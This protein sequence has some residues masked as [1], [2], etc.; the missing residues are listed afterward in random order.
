MLHRDIWKFHNG[1]IPEGHHIHHED[2]DFNNNEISNLVCLSSAAH[3]V[4]HREERSARAKSPKHLAHLAAIRPLANEWHKT[5]ECRAWAREQAKRSILQDWP[6]KPCIIC[7]T[8][9]KPKVTKA[10]MCSEE[11]KRQQRNT[12]MRKRYSSKPKNDIAKRKQITERYC[13]ICGSV[14]I[15]ASGR[16]LVCGSECRREKTR[17][18]ARE[19]YHSRLRSDGG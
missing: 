14:F 9:F 11:C 2:G 12:L 1:E 19:Q 17:R 3:Q 15:P 4:E 7:G 5:E 10:S 6:E 16:S 8:M 13:E 18:K